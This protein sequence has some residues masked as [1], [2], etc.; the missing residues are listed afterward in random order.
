MSEG[1]KSEDQAWRGDATLT[2]VLDAVIAKPAPLAY[3]DTHAGAGLYPLDD[4]GE[5]CGGVVP[6]RAHPREPMPHCVSRYLDCVGS[7]NTGTSLRRYPGSA[8]IAAHW[9]RPTDRLLLCERHPADHAERL[10]RTAVVHPA[11]DDAVAADREIEAP[12]L[13]ACRIHPRTFPC[14]ETSDSCSTSRLR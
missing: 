11:G 8:T 14:A 7:L 1:S 13:L 12:T 2:A 10:L 6:L 3:V 9:L 4:D 5:Q